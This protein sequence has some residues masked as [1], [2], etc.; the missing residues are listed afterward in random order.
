MPCL[1]VKD[2]VY[3]RCARLLLA[4]SFTLLKV[5]QLAEKILN[6]VTLL[7]EDK[8]QFYRSPPSLEATKFS[9]V[10]DRKQFL[11]N[12]PS[13]LANIYCVPLSSLSKELDTT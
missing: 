6:M 4:L 11:S 10:R 1:P 8:S 3:V 9:P 7:T 12:I 13:P 5:L 2:P